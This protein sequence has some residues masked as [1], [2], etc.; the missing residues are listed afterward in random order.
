MGDVDGQSSGGA[1]LASQLVI[2]MGVDRYFS[3]SEDEVMYGEVLLQPL[4][5]QDDIIR[6]ADAVSYVVLKLEM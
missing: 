4:S 3:S 1:A 2:N 6:L 5:F